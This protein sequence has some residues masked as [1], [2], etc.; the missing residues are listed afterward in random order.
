MAFCLFHEVLIVGENA[1]PPIRQAL[2]R[3]FGKTQNVSIRRL[4][5]GT[6]HNLVA[7]D[8]LRVGQALKHLSLHMHHLVKQVPIKVQQRTQRR[9]TVIMLMRPSGVIDLRRIALSF[10]QASR[11]F[12][13]PFMH[14]LIDELSHWV[15]SYREDLYISES[16]FQ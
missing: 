9:N 3:M 1:T 15:L 2:A 6:Y 11:K 14:H 8:V 10:A 16:G 13:R 4:P 12:G 7:Q 5:S